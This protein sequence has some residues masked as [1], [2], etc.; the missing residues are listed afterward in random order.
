MAAVVPSESELNAALVSLRAENAT[1]GITKIHALLLSTH[2]T[3][4]V[5]EKRTRKVLQAEGLMVG[6]PSP[7]LGLG[8]I[9]QSAPNKNAEPKVYPKSHVIEGLD[10][11]KW[12]NKVE[13]RYF[14]KIKGKGL[15]AK[16]SIKQGEVVWKEDPFVVAPEWYVHVCA[17]ILSDANLQNGGPDKRDIFDLQQ[18]SPSRACAFCTTPFFGDSA[19]VIPCPA[20][21][22]TT[23]SRLGPSQRH[24]CPARF[25]NRLCLT[26]SAGTH[27]LLCP[28]QNPASVALVAF[29]RRH[30]WMALHALALCA[31]RVLLAGQRDDVPVGRGALD[32]DLGVLKAFATLGME[33]RVREGS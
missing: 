16:D 28:V 6:Q 26:R 10:V 2:P 18:C 20:S 15:V 23:G 5:S 4:T 21:G 27:P 24:R 25:C 33:E 3:W 32:A 12:T 30:E 17:T 22:S 11:G 19:L 1:L 31:A 7:G 9:S 14:G 13:V 29:A 8:Y